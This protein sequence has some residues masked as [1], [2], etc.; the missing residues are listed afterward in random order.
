MCSCMLHFEATA[1]L[2]ILVGKSPSFLVAFIGMWPASSMIEG[3]VWPSVS[4]SLL[5]P[6][7]LR[8]AFARQVPSPLP[9]YQVSRHLYPTLEKPLNQPRINN[10][11]FP[12]EHTT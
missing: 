8:G 11:P 9:L 2:V 3:D 10:R 6:P 5:N 1:F 4:V 7:V 12:T